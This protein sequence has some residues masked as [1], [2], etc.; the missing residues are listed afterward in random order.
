MLNQ[1]RMKLKLKDR[2]GAHR[3]LLF[4]VII[5][6]A[7]LIFR[8]LLSS[9]RF[10]VSFDE[11]NYLKLGISASQNGLSSVFHTY[12]SPFY[13]LVVALF[14]KLS[15]NYELVGRLV[16]IVASVLVLP[17]IYYF[18]KAV[19][20]QKIARV[21]LVLLAF[22]PSLAFFSTRAQTEPLYTLIITLGIFIGWFALNRKVYWLNLVV[23]LLFGLAY[24]TK[25][26]GLGFVIV[27]VGIQGLLFLIS[28]FKKQTLFFG[29]RDSLL[30]VAGFLIVA[31]PYLIFLKQA[32]GQW[33]ISAKGKA[34]QQFEAQASGLSGVTEDVFRKLNANNTQVPIDQIYHL[35]SFI[36]A[37]EERGTPTIKV[38]PLIVVRK[39]VENLYKVL[40]DG[41]NHALTSIILVLLMLGLFSEPW[42]QERTLRELYL[43]SYLLF[44]WMLVIPL[45][46]INDRYFLPLLPVCFIWVGKGLVTLVDW[47]EN[48]LRNLFH[49]SKLKVNVNLLALTTVIGLIVLGL[50]LPQLGKILNRNRWSTEYWAEPVEQKIAGLWIKEFGKPS[51]VI[52]SRGRTVD[53]YAGNYNIAETVTVPKN[54]LSRVLEYARNRG[55]QYL[56]LNERYLAAYPEL[57]FLLREETVSAGLELVFKYDSKPGLKTLVYQIVY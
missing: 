5:T 39:Y 12:W 27:F 24:L 11:V 51:P 38:S 23:G 45:F 49:F 54:E 33:T 6:S 40:A 26:E 46:H 42:T 53:F 16:S 57:S 21:S 30:T 20:D 34:N 17:P 28:L 37:E 56:V 22:Y 4:V 3:D 14:A 32:T 9:Y 55:V 44:F 41:A 43:L 15:S 48:T 50:Y 25:P 2:T 29:L 19:F 47:L 18:S 8:L 1:V 36:Q 31:A 13:P 35:G 10:A 7:A 52:M